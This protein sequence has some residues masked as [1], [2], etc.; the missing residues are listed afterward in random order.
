MRFSTA[1]PSIFFITL[2][3]ISSSG[4][5][6]MGIV[7][8][9][10]PDKKRQKSEYPAPAPPAIV[11]MEPPLPMVGKGRA[12]RLTF[13]DDFSGDEIDLKKWIIRGDK[14][15][16]NGFWLK[17]N[18]ELD[19]KGFLRL[20]TMRDVD[21]ESGEVSFSGGALESK[22]AF[23]QTYGY[24]IAR[25]KLQETSGEGYHCSFWL[26]SESI[27]NE[28][29]AG[30]NGTEIDVIEKFY[31][32]GLVQHALHWDGYK[33]AHAKSNFRFPWPGINDDFHTFAV[34]WT[35]EEY[36]FFID[37][38]ETWRTTAGGVSQVPAFIRLTTEFSEKWNGKIAEAKNLPDTFI[39]DWVK[40]YS[41]V[42]E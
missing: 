19:G 18:A 39:V 41:L 12:L 6:E 7:E 40:A 27:G 37:G 34:L 13:S 29:D 5:D 24:W 20:T 30:R 36:T 8:L 15:R 26:Q 4:A 9:V 10:L 35:P 14:P 17:K 1:I 31:K 42:S 23:Q 32:D 16:A 22:D 38:V 3:G 28:R 33:K 25:A 21:A 11:P 2:C